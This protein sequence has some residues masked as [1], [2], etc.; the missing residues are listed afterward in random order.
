M[1]DEMTRQEFAAYM[2]AF[3]KRLDARF[4]QLEKRVTGGFAETERRFAEAEKRV[5]SEFAETDRRFAEAERRV[6]AGFAETDRRFAETDRRFEEV[7]ARITAAEQRLDQRLTIGFEEATRLTKLSLEGLEVLRERTDRGFT[8]MK[9][10]HD[11]QNSLLQD[12][13]RHVRKRVDQLGRRA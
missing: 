1:D 10:R 12:A 7:H 2:T 8:E 13:I 4:D 6:V 5:T 11:A 3:E 9:S